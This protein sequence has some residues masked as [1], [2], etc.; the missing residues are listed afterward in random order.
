MNKEI[1]KTLGFNEEVKRIEDG[2]CPFCCLPVEE[3]DF[4]DELSKRFNN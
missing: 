2:K 1:L 4:K 3:S